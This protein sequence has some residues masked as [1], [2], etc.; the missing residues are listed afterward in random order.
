M[1]G[2]VIRAD[3]MEWPLQTFLD[4][5]GFIRLGDHAPDRRE[6]LDF[7]DAVVELVVPERCYVSGEE[8]G[9][10]VISAPANEA[11]RH[12]PIA[13]RPPEG[14]MRVDLCPACGEWPVP[15][16]VKTETREGGHTIILERDICAR[17]DDEPWW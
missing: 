4:A 2:A 16:A 8:L 11:E 12:D 15:V 14:S 13:M 17:C 5:R 6:L 10:E 1:S 3:G 7:G 9:F